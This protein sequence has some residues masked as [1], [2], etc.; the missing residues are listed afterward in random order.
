[1]AMKLGYGPVSK[2]GPTISVGDNVQVMIQTVALAC[3]CLPS[4][5]SGLPTIS[6]SQGILTNLLQNIE[7]KTETLQTCSF[8]SRPL[9]DIILFPHATE[10]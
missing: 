5:E 1:M 3:T 9:L 6:T 7:P 8:Q 4:P 10:G 2:Y